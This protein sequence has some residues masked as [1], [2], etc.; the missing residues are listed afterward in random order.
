VRPLAVAYAQ[1]HAAST[2]ILSTKHG[3]VRPEQII[4]PYEQTL[5]GI[6]RAKR[7]RWAEMVHRQLRVVREYQVAKTILWLAGEDYR[8]EL[9][10]LVETECDVPMEGLAY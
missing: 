4:E 5:I 3:V 10:P 9:L 8:G 7:R 6:S 1:E 2:L